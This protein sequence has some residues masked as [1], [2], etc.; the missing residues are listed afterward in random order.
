MGLGI[1]SQHHYHRKMLNPELFKLWGQ[2]EA[3]VKLKFTYLCKR[4]YQFLVDESI[5][6]KKYR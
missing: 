5:L 2:F 3:A 1:N 4:K 6:K